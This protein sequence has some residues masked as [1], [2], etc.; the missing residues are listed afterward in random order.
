MLPKHTNI[1]IRMA[2]QPEGMLVSKTVPSSRV[3]VYQHA[4]VSP[5]LGK[6][7]L[8]PFFNT[9]FVN[10]GGPCAEKNKLLRKARTFSLAKLH[11]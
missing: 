8:S 2:V 7:I 6:L 9:A 10:L 1:G 5:F 3:P 11:F 4:T